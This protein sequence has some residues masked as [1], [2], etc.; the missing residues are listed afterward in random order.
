MKK[1]AVKYSLE[2]VVIVLGITI[3]YWINDIQIQNQE[4]EK[5][6]VILNSI[7]SDIEQIET[8]INARKKTLS[9]DSIWMDYLIKNWDNVNIDSSYLTIDIQ[10]ELIVD[11]VK[12]N[13]KQ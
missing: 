12:N 10:I 7:L 9:S 5:E 2:F 11:E 3:S 8:Y 4:S 1:H 13:N 6:K